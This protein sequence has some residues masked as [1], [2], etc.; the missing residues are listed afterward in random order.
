MANANIPPTLSISKSVAGEEKRHAIIG[1][2]ML[3]SSTPKT[4][5]HD[6]MRQWGSGR[7]SIL[8]Q[9]GRGGITQ[10]V[11]EENGAYSCAGT[12]VRFARYGTTKSSGGFRK[13][14]HS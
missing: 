6:V 8:I 2:L 13:D 7:S 12:S 4:I 3:S 14:S 10:W 9:Y 5:D 1:S 11:G